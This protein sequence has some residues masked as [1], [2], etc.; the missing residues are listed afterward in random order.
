[1]NSCGLLPPEQNIPQILEDRLHKLS[2]EE[3]RMPISSGEGDG[4]VQAFTASFNPEPIHYTDFLRSAGE[5]A[6]QESLNS[7]AG[8]PSSTFPS[9]PLLDGPDSNVFNSDVSQSKNIGTSAT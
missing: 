1:M 8:R 2:N 4:V 5:Q 7:W 9:E 6:S 3:S